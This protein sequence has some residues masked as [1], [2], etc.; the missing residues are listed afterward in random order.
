MNNSHQSSLMH[1]YNRHYFAAILLA[2]SSLVILSCA[3]PSQGSSNVASSVDSTTVEEDTM[4]REK[5]IALFTGYFAIVYKGGS[6]PTSVMTYEYF[7]KLDPVGSTCS[8]SDE[9]IHNRLGYCGTY[10]QMPQAWVV[11]SFDLD[12]S[13]KFA[14]VGLKRVDEYQFYGDHI[15]PYTCTVRLELDAQNNLEMSL[16][17]GE[18]GPGPLLGTFTGDHSLYDNVATFVRNARLE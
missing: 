4:S 14:I 9:N 5:A 18:V 3:N 17:E 1:C 8:W 15:E 10:N 13:F 2:I 12:D 11:T 6:T 7:L 16:V